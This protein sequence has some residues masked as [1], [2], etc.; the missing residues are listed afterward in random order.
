MMDMTSASFSLCV[1]HVG[2]VATAKALLAAKLMN[3]LLHSHS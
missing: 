1:V 2:T 3:R